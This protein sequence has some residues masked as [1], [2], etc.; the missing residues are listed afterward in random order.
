M[1]L[2][3]TVA[4]V[5]FLD[6]LLISV[7]WVFSL[8]QASYL[9]RWKLSKTLQLWG[10]CVMIYFLV[11]KTRCLC[12]F[13]E[14]VMHSCTFNHLY[15][16]LAAMQK[17]NKSQQ[18]D[19]AG[20]EKATT[21]SPESTKLARDTIAESAKENVKE[22]GDAAVDSRPTPAGESHEEERDTTTPDVQ[23]NSMCCS[24]FELNYYVPR[25]RTESA[26]GSLHY[27]GSVLWNK[28]PSEIR[29]LPSLNLFKTSFHGKGFSNTPWPIVTLIIH[30]VSFCIF[31]IIVNSS[32]EYF[33]LVLNAIPRKTM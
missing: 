7:S 12:L 26:K 2:R 13:S 3:K 1:F 8:K 23:I 19:E 22:N 28:I 18:S 5:N 9:R 4:L 24:F 11:K 10:C 20:P 14:R 31:N 16:A 27:R 29:K 17:F 30:S 15:C 32:L 25:P 21:Q 6:F 33:S